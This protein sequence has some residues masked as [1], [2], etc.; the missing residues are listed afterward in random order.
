LLIAFGWCLLRCVPQRVAWLNEPSI[1]GLPLRMPYAIG[2][3][4]SGRLSI[5]IVD[6]LTTP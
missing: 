3:V 5:G 1:A 4:A 6:A 2:A